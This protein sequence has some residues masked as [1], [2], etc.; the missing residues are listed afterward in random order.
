MKTK[1]SN[2]QNQ[3]NVLLVTL[4]ITGVL[5]LTLA[6]YLTMIASQNRS[7]VRS[8]TWNSSIPLAEAGIEEAIVHLNKNCLWNPITSAPVN[9][10]AD[11][12]E[13]VEDG[14]EM[15]RHLGENY[16][17][18]RISTN[19]PYSTNSPGIFSKG[20]VPASMANNSSSTL[21]A[22]V[23]VAGDES[24]RR[25]VGRQVRVTTGK[26]GFFTRAMVAKDSID[27]KGNQIQTDSFD[28]EDPAFNTGGLYDPTKHK[29]NGD[30]AVNNGLEDSLNIGNAD[31]YGAV[32]VGPGGTI[33]IGPDGKVGD[34]AWMA[35]ATKTGIQPGR[36]RDDMNVSLPNVEAPTNISYTTPLQNL[37]VT[38]PVVSSSNVTFTSTGYPTNW[39]TVAT[40][41][42]PQ[43]TT[44]YPS[45]GTYIG[46][47]LTN[48]SPVTTT[49]TPGDGTYVGTVATNTASTVSSN[50]PSSGTYIGNVVTNYSWFTIAYPG[51]PSGYYGSVITNTASTTTD[52]PPAAG[53]YVGAV[54]VNSSGN[55]GNI[56]S[57]T[58]NRI[59]SYSY[60]KATGYGYERITGY[61][62]EKINSYTVAHITGYTLTQSVYYTNYVVEFYDY[63]F[64]S[65]NYRV[66]TI[67]GKVL[68][69]GNA[70]VLITDDV[71][72]T[73]NSEDLHIN[74][75]ASLKLYMA[76]ESFAV[77]GQG[78]INPGGNA[79]RFWYFGLPSNTHI[80]LTGNADFT[81]VIYAPQA[82][83]AL[84]G[85]GN[86]TLDLIGATVTGSVQMNGHFNFHYDEALSRK[87]PSRGY[88]ING[89]EEVD[90]AE[91]P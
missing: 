25:Y 43:T 47:V 49:G 10:Y 13:S 85:S 81:G 24:E 55:S 74:P 22:A 21:L 36:S 18:V 90:I 76:G 64:D 91:T 89:W 33:A 27:L 59:V 63:V 17:I 4:V 26:D 7:V 87:G 37:W 1:S 31:I 46:S 29:D 86:D 48:T 84:S 82:N 66:S 35:D 19:A 40:N 60:Q 58:Y 62:Y 42:T 9:W 45:S 70:L 68:I 53:S 69:R 8:Q 73:G 83:L 14:I 3:G 38:N 80:A 15:T 57:Y 16:Y 88:L 20:Y 11:G 34:A 12:W 32:A 41:T 72:M 30:V 78:E 51:Y 44:S 28:S 61:T 77:K 79:D 54:T 23:G 39:G 52:N 2:R 50:V 65:D 71:D 56:K 75:D 5:G 67:N 6:S